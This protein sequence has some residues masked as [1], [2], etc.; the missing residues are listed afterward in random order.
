MK[1]REVVA[2]LR[3]RGQVYESPAHAPDGTVTAGA[4]SA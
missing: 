3:A 4:S 2:Q 1:V